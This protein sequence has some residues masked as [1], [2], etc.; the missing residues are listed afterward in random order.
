MTGTLK[1]IAHRPTDG[2]PMRD[3]QQATVHPGRGIDSENRKTGRREVTLLSAE[4]W[5]DACGE[6]GVDIPWLVRRANFLIE[7]VD[8]AATVGQVISIGPVQ[9][10][11]HGETKPCGIME[12]QQAGLRDALK[13]NLRGGV[14]GEVLTSG[15][16]CVGD[17][18]RLA[19][20]M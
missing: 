7:G 10:R 6:L 11:I 12:S 1:G 14:H 20:S 16:I 19:K 3:A 13:P 2:E 4:S 9:I 5:A 8:L 18:V 15:T 17:P